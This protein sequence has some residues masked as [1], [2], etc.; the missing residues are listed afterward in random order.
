MLGIELNP[1][2]ALSYPISFALL[3]SHLTDEKIRE[4]LCY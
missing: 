1:L 2:V 4:D 3:V